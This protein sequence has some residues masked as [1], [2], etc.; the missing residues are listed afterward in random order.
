MTAT[1]SQ[2][3]KDLKAEL[4]DTSS[5]CEKCNQ[6][7][8][9]LLLP[10]KGLNDCDC[11]VPVGN[12]PSSVLLFERLNRLVEFFDTHQIAEKDRLKVDH[13]DLAEI[14]GLH[15]YLL[16]IKAGLSSNV[17]KVNWMK[18]MYND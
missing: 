12:G 10:V 7:T 6:S 3:I 11:G 17:I 14:Q 9:A 2:T 13:A 1:L 5:T 16:K 18:D 8:P 4:L 15:S